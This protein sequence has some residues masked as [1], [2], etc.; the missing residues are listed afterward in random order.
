M[1]HVD[2]CR[3]MSETLDLFFTI[4][5]SFVISILF[6]ILGV[7]RGLCADSRRKSTKAYTPIHD[8][9]MFLWKYQCV[10][11]CYLTMFWGVGMLFATLTALILMNH[12]SCT[13]FLIVSTIA[14]ATNPRSGLLQLAPPK[15]PVSGFDISVNLSRAFVV[16]CR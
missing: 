14:Q 1:I 5:P 4:I 13:G 3:Y 7:V 2:T 10:L 15:W 12:C 9:G 11:Y 8:R 16:M 6:C